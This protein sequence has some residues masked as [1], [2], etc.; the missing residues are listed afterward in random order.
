MCS[1]GQTTTKSYF[2]RGTE[3]PETS[4]K[5]RFESWEVNMDYN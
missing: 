2:R 1:D 4:L 5:V 3:V